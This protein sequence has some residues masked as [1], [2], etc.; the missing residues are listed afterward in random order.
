[1]KELRLFDLFVVIL[2]SV[3]KRFEE[4]VIASLVFDSPKSFQGLQVPQIF[5]D[6]STYA[7]QPALTP[8]FA[9]AVRIFDRH[10]GFTCSCKIRLWET[11]GSK[12][13]G[14]GNWNVG[15]IYNYRVPQVL[16]EVDLGLTVWPEEGCLGF[17]TARVAAK[18]NLRRPFQKPV[19]HVSL[20]MTTCGIA[21]HVFV[22]A[23]H[24]NGGE[25]D[26]RICLG[27]TV[28]HVKVDKQSINFYEGANTNLRHQE[29]PSSK[30]LKELESFVQDTS[31][32]A[33]ASYAI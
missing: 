8:R 32:I 6:I 4:L 31:I 26:V 20:T 30:E 23:L 24:V 5:Q 33:Y 17:V 18:L 11:R 1:M 2:V 12:S 21:W 3:R 9:S 16:I 28:H 10:V 27:S 25:H 7:H 19:K 14:Y 29:K 13:V 22:R 15:E